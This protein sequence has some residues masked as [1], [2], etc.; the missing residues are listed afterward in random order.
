MPWKDIGKF[1]D[2]A[3]KAMLLYIQQVSPS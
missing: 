2:D 1:D 3:L